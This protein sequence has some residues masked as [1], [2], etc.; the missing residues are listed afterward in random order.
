MLSHVETHV[1]RIKVKAG[2]LCGRVELEDEV[3][4]AALDHLCAQVFLTSH[5]LLTSHTFLTSHAFLTSHM[6]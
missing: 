6:F 3:E 4:S 1:S 5:T 2:E